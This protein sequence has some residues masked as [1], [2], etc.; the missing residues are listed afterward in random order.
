MPEITTFEKIQEVTGRK[1]SDCACNS[2]RM[3]CTQTPC[4]GTPE[5]ILKLLMAG[6]GERL[7]VTIWAAGIF[8]GVVDHPIEIIAPLYDSTK[9]ACT[10]FNN[11]LCELHDKGLKPTEGKL[12]HHSITLEN[13]I[14]EKSI[15][16]NVVKEWINLDVNEIKNI[17]EKIYHE[18][19]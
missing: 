14:A 9:G 13:F 11:G 8:M 16:W 6:Y 19:V 7:V 3:Q 2:C 18:Q 15:A 5:D 12:S 1:S 17:L 10:F 4:L